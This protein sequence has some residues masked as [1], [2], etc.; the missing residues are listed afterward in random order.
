MNVKCLAVRQP[1]AWLLVNGTTVGITANA[2]DADGTTNTVALIQL[3]ANRAVIWTKPDDLDAELPF[4]ALTKGFGDRV[5]LGFGDGTVR[6]VKFPLKE[7]VF[8]N[9]LNK[10]DGNPIPQ[11]D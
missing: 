11:I 9:L 8:R 5:N 4:D 1:W 6:R 3:P 2:T 7:E 10:A